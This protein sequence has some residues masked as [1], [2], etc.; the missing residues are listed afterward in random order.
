MDINPAD[1]FYLKNTDS[2]L[3]LTLKIQRY[4]A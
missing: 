2:R 3:R 4:I 1:L